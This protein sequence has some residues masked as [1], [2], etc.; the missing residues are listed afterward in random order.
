MRVAKISLIMIVLRKKSITDMFSRKPVSIHNLIERSSHRF[1]HLKRPSKCQT[2]TM[3]VLSTLSEISYCV[4]YGG[5]SAR[6][7]SFSVGLHTIFYL[8]HGVRGHQMNKWLERILPWVSCLLAT[9]EH[10]F[11]MQNVDDVGTNQS[12]IENL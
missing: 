12:V 9:P 3:L 6:A 8:L 1:L 10:T 7:V 2:L 4:L 11:K 5:E